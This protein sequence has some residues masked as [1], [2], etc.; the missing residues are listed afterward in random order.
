MDEGRFSISADALYRRLGSAAAPIVVDVRRARA[1]DED[2][3]MIVGA[4]RCPPEELAA[5]QHG[6]TDS[7]PFVVYRVHGH[8]VSQGAPETL[9]GFG[10]DARYLAG[11]IGAW[12]ERSL[13]TQPRAT[14]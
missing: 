3:R 9:R 10:V 5:W 4:F 7:R 14:A 8:E 13:P 11:G 2:E 12:T 6:R 1:F